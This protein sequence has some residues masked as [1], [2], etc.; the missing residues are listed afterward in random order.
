MS[1]R[2]KVRGHS[3]NPYFNGSHHCLGNEEDY[4]IVSLVR[5][6]KIGFL[7]NLRR[8]N[9]MLTRCKK[10][11]FICTSRHFLDGNDAKASLMG[12][13]A[14]TLGEQAWL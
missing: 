6:E 13:L 8:T 9:V 5:S 4:I 10:G 2:S 12:R 1:I 3:N 14:G 11:M 7:S